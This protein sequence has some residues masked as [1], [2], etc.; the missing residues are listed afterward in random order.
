MGRVTYRKAWEAEFVASAAGRAAFVDVA[1]TI[2]ADTVD[3]LKR[4]GL[5]DDPPAREYLAELDTEATGV[6]DTDPS[7][8]SSYTVGRP[9]DASLR[10]AQTPSQPAVTVAGTSSG[11]R[12]D[13]TSKVIVVPSAMLWAS[14][15]DGSIVSSRTTQSQ[16]RRQPSRVSST[17]VGVMGR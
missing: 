17:R 2:R 14:S 11:S 6:R 8:P 15:P 16:R 12:P 10:K 7:N 9:R 5:L 1:E 4:T 3:E 13:G